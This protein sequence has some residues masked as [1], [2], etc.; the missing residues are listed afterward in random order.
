ME[1]VVAQVRDLVRPLRDLD[2][3]ARRQ[4][5]LGRRRV[6]V[7]LRLLKNTARRRQQAATLC[8]RERR[9]RLNGLSSQSA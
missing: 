7:R 6:R 1:Q 5:D 2:A 4:V 8:F 3:R 9:R